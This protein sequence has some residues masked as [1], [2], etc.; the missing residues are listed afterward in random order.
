MVRSV[1]GSGTINIMGRF[2]GRNPE[3]LTPAEVAVLKAVYTRL[4]GEALAYV[5]VRDGPPAPS[6]EAH[7]RA[8]ARVDEAEI[9]YWR[10]RR[11][12]LGEE[13]PPS[14]QRA[15]DIAEWFSDDDDVYDDLDLDDA[16]N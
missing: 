14:A 15:A 4:K 8:L 1:L 3:D 10:A 12:I 16:I 6:D 7:A 11:E 5:G 13:R 9:E 2:S